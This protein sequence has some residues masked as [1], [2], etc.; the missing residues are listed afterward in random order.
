MAQA[1][2]AV[3][4]D[5]KTFYH[6]RTVWSL[7]RRHRLT[8]LLLAA[9]YSILALPATVLKTAPYYIGNTNDGK[10]NFTASEV[11]DY[12]NT[13][14]F[15]A[16]LYIFPA[17]VCLRM[18]AARQYATAMLTDYHNGHLSF[19]D[20]EPREQQELKRLELFEYTPRPARHLLVRAMVYTGSRLVG[21]LMLVVTIAIWFSFIA[22]VYVSEFLNYHPVVGWLNQPLV[23][24][25]W[26]RYIPMSL[27]NPWGEIFLSFLLIVIL[28]VGRKALRGIAGFLIPKQQAT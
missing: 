22:Q 4:G 2:Q 9:A 21:F 18:W 8:S 5:W 24:L 14:H 16:A 6:F 10:E 23:Q 13:Y 12:L 25:P 7:L 11:L 3:T 17:I 26:F 28:L 1:R 19:E 20:L 15:W 27:Q